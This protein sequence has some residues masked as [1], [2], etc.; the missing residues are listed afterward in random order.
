MSLIEF[1]PSPKVRTMDAVKTKVDALALEW[2][3]HCRR[4]WFSSNLSDYLDHSSYQAL[5]ALGAEALPFMGTAAFAVASLFF[6]TVLAAFTGA[7]TFVAVSLPAFAGV[8]VED[9]FPFTAAEATA[10]VASL[11]TAAAAFFRLFGGLV[12]FFAARGRRRC[13]GGGGAGGE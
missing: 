5:A 3:A 6:S 13:T 11:S 1:L 2:A 4:M 10:S 8:A 9:S 12:S 7:A